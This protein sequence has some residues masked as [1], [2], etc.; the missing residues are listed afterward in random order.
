M[1]HKMKLERKD[2]Y[3]RTTTQLLK[4]KIQATLL[5]KPLAKPIFYICSY[6][7]C[8][9]F[10]IFLLNKTGGCVAAG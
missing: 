10:A 1:G 9:N 2:N 8:S 5:L 3:V 4:I 6:Y 7:R